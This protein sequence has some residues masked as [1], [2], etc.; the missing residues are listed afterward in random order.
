MNGLGGGHNNA[1]LAVNHQEQKHEIKEFGSLFHL[2][3]PF[4]G[5]LLQH[6]IDV[7]EGKL[8]GKNNLKLLQ[9]F[10]IRSASGKGVNRRK[11]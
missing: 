2:F 6:T 3:Q 7:F 11:C 1:D 8:R 9:E 10:S 5:Q 4:P